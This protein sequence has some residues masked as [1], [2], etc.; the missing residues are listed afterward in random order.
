VIVPLGVKTDQDAAS[1]LQEMA[2]RVIEHSA[3]SLSSF[4]LERTAGLLLVYAN[5]SDRELHQWLR[6]IRIRDVQIPILVVSRCNDESGIVLTLR[7]GADD[8]L[9]NGDRYLEM[10]A[11]IQSLV[12]RRMRA[13]ARGAPV[14]QIIAGDVALDTQSRTLRCANGTCKLT[15]TEFRI[16]MALIDAEGRTLT[17]AQL[18]LAAGVRASGRLG[19]GRSVDTHVHRLRKALGDNPRQAQHIL[20]EPQLG[21]RFVSRTECIDAAPPVSL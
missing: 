19:V 15:R 21:Y 10:E 13:S 8:V 6:L 17:R 2:Y 14:A 5:A 1:A 18:N 4:P 7:A 12:R 11:R 3:A 16:M 20:S 9:A